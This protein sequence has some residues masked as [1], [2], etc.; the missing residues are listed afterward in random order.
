MCQLIPT[1]PTKQDELFSKFWKSAALQKYKKT[2]VQLEDEDTKPAQLEIPDVKF[3]MEYR[4]SRKNL[5]RSLTIVLT[6]LLVMLPKYKFQVTYLT[7]SRNIIFFKHQLMIN[8]NS[9]LR[10]NLV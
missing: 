8:L 10:I 7:S 9:R 2:L 4:N 3:I 6:N 1:I 5:T